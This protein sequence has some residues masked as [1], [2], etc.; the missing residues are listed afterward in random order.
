MNRPRSRRKKVNKFAWVTTVCIAIVLV[1]V[2][3]VIGLLAGVVTE[4]P[5]LVFDHLRGKSAEVIM[6]DIDR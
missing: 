2:G 4:E 3:F 1:G 5:R 6:D